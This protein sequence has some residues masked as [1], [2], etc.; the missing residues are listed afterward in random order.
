MESVIIE[1]GSPSRPRSRPHSRVRSAGAPPPAS[2]SGIST[3]SHDGLLTSEEGLLSRP[4][5]RP[6]SRRGRNRRRGS[7]KLRVCSFTQGSRGQVTMCLHCLRPADSELIPRT[8]RL[9]TLEA[10]SP[11]SRT[12]SGLL[13]VS[14]QGRGRERKAVS[15]LTRAAIPS[16]GR[17]P[18]HPITPRGPTSQHHHTGAGVSAHDFGDTHSVHNVLHLTHTCV[19]SVRVFIGKYAS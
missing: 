2:N 5:S 14:P 18:P 11:E 6:C 15:L 12:G 3:W 7:A 13:A 16:W 9:S 17:H 1:T 10:G 8:G 4:A 19:L